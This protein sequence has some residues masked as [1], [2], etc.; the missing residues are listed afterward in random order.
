MSGELSRPDTGHGSNGESDKSTLQYTKEQQTKRG[1]FS[2]KKPGASSPPKDSSISLE[3]GNPGADTS[4]QGP[5]PVGLFELFRYGLRL[6]RFQY[7]Y[8]TLLTALDQVFNEGRAYMERRHSGLCG[9]SR[10]SASES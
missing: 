2:R 6:C 8:L 1:F 10:I 7:T 3:G 4:K 9:S 5:P